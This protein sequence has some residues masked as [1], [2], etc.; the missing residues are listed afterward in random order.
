[1]STEISFSALMLESAPNVQK[2]VLQYQ[3]LAYGKP[4]SQSN[5]KLSYH[6]KTMQCPMPVEVSQLLHNLRKI[7]YQRLAIAE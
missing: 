6:T 5:K 4:A 7:I 2:T 3:R 1:M